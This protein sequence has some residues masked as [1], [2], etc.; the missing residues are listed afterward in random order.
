MKQSVLMTIAIAILLAAFAGLGG[1]G[2]DQGIIIA[3]VGPD[4][5]YEQD[6]NDIYETGQFNFASFEEEFDSRRDMTDSLVIQQLLIQEAY[7]RNL[8]D[9]EE[10]NR[11]ILASR[12]RFLLDI[13]YQRKI[14][15]PVDIGEE[16]IKDL[17]GKLEFKVHASHILVTDKDTADMILDSLKNGGSFEQLAVT[18]SVDP[19]AIQNR[20]DI[21][22]YVWGQLDS[23]FQENLWKLNPGEMSEPFETR[24]GWHIARMIDRQPNE[25][26][27][28]YG[29][30]AKQ[31]EM[32]LEGQQRNVLL[33]EYRDELMEKYPVRVDSVTCQ[34]L[35]HKRESLYPPS[36]LANLPRN[37]FDIAQL[38]GHERELVIAG[39]EGGQMTL[40]QYLGRI[41]RLDAKFKPDFDNYD[42]L[43]EVIFQ[44]EFNSILGLEARRI[45]LE[46]DPEFKRKIKRFKELAMADV[47]RN[48]SLPIP[49][50]PDDGEIRQYY[51]DNQGEFLI[52]EEVHLFE[53]MFNDLSAAK[54]YRHK[55]NGLTRFKQLATEYTQRTGMKAKQGDMGWI[56]EIQ[57]PRLFNA[58][59]DVEVGEVGGPVQIG[60][61]HSLVFVADRKPEQIKDF[62]MVKND[63]RDQLTNDRK[64]ESF[65]NWVQQKKEEITAKIYE[66]NIRASIDQDKYETE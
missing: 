13:L 18:Y 17:Y 35:L 33:T 58:A 1:C 24:F 51:E 65:A 55:I 43:A 38:D 10:I 49:D 2:S 53:I 50:P 12:D 11:V 22:F 4:K 40:G 37:D 19:S 25:L 64:N 23:V 36:L 54:T 3:K 48:D 15:D 63:I 21:G 52:P 28:T 60:S 57:Y 27:T 46:D 39:W 62:L 61:K 34:Y 30:M 42:G 32:S 9:M 6:L 8:D 59:R 56:T 41:K 44:L 7:R 31:L 26:R 45:G 14:I 5:I 29:K 66:N 20:G 16:D 47:M